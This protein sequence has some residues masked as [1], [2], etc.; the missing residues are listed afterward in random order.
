METKFLTLRHP[1]EL[2]SR[3][4]DWQVCWLG[5]WDRHQ[6]FYIVMLVK[7]PF[8][9][10]WTRRTYEREAGRENAAGKDSGGGK[11]QDYSSDFDGVGS[12]A[13]IAFG[14]DHRQSHFFADCT[15]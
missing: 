9:K 1:V 12:L 15:G 8:K 2:G 14:R 6:Y 3:F 13:V 4:D 5:G 10:R 11:E 7:L